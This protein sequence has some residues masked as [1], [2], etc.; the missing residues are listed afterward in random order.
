MKYKNNSMKKIRN[1]HPLMVSCSHCGQELL[2]YQKGGRGNLIKLQVH[3]IIESNI[4]LT[5]LENA[6]NCPNCSEQ[7]ASLTEY[8]GKP[9]YYIIRGKARDKRMGHYRY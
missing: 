3:R 4:D 7:I 2:I 5:K 8:N 1:T 9:T 6:L